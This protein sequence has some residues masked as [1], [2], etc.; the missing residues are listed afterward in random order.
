MKIQLS[1]FFGVDIS[2][3]NIPFKWMPSLDTLSIDECSTVGLEFRN[4]TFNYLRK[5]LRKKP[6]ISEDERK[7]KQTDL[8]ITTTTKKIQTS[9]C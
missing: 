8:K 4:P 5:S 7:R 2:S 6:R 1:N 9:E 3:K